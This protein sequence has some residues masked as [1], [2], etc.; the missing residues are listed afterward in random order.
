MRTLVIAEHD[1]AE[2]KT[3]TLKT[4]AAA[5]EIC[6]DFDI[7]VAGYNCDQAARKAA[8]IPGTGKVLKADARELEH[9]LPENLAPIIAKLAHDYSHILAPASA[10]GKNVLPRAAALTGCGQ[11]SAISRVIDPQ[12]FERPVY[13]GNA[14]ETLKILQKVNFITVLLSS[15]EASP[16]SEGNAQIVEINSP[17]DSGLSKFISKENDEAGRPDLSSAGIVVAGGQGMESAEDFRLVEQLADKLGA[18]V[19]ITRNAA[20]RGFGPNDLQI[21]QSGKVISPELYIAAGISGTIQHVSGIRSSK[22]IVAINKDENA[23]IFEYA[24]YGLVMDALEALPE[25]IEKL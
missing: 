7:L 12:T 25:L 4:V 1:N 3:A 6:P 2:L 11:I 13:A 16:A 23:Q 19:G 9:F 20:D 17:G 18:A 14:I 15:F 24:D 10:F 21:G 5:K 22:I 8:I